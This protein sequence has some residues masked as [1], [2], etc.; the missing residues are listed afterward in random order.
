MA[1]YIARECPKC[2]DYFGVVISHPSPESRELPVLADCAGC[3]F[4]LRGWRVI[5]GGKRATETSI[6]RMRKALS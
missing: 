5:L 3:G 2:R 6:S 4:Q 1:K